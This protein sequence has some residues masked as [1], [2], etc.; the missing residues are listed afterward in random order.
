M[1]GPEP[2]TAL[3]VRQILSAPDL[4]A[5]AIYQLDVTAE[6][7]YV[8]DGVG[9]EEVNGYFKVRISPGDAPNP[10]G[11]FD[12]NVDLLISTTKE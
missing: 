6:G 12:E 10:L 5:R 9:P 3:P 7:R 11:R 8:A 4:S 1:P 2:R